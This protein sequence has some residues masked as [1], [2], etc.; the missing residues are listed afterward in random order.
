MEFGHLCLRIFIKGSGA[1]QWAYITGKKSRHVDGRRIQFSDKIL[2]HLW[3]AVNYLNSEEGLE[4]LKELG[5]SE[6]PDHIDGLVNLIANARVDRDI[7]RD[8]FRLFLKH[9]HKIM[10]YL[11]S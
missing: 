2:K 11:L 1:T 4:E 10:R 8:Q 7:K 6:V 5:I 3:N 9:K